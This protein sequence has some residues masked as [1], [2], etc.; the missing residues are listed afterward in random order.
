M[1][2]QCCIDP[3]RVAPSPIPGLP[4]QPKGTLRTFGCLVLLLALLLQA[5]C[6]NLP[7]DYPRSTST[8]LADTGDTRLG[9]AARR[10]LAG[11]PD[12]SGVHPLN[13]G[14]D[15]FLARLAL[16]EAAEKSLDIQ[17]Y[18]WHGD[19]TG[20][21][22]LE[23]VLRAADRSV[24]VRLLLDDIGT[25]AEDSHL[26]AIDSHPNIEVRLFNPV[27]ARSTPLLG[28]MADFSRTN[29]RMHNKSFTA[30]NQVMIVGGRN[31]GDEYFEARPDVAF[32][33][34]DLLAIGPVV[35]EVSRQFDRY[36]NS[37]L[38]FPISASPRPCRVM[39]R[40]FR[41]LPGCGR[42]CSRRPRKTMPRHSS[43][44]GWPSGWPRAAYPSATPRPAWRPT[45]R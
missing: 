13:R 17:Y 38:A 5:G 16:T 1:P 19:T 15:A 24:R 11:H 8:V 20:K 29:R 6:A 31:I 18:I 23:R 14:T 22:L 45:I 42:S 37:P 40:S 36:W 41:H 32:A 30:D 34:L 21:V 35:G 25:A 3:A 12:T 33:D 43:R 4:L 7:T 44:R 9:Q 27:A 10:M 26:L 2:H 39:R 28:M